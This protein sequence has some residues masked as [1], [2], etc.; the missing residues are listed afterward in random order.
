MRKGLFQDL[1]T[2]TRIPLSLW[3]FF[4]LSVVI[5]GLLLFM[6]AT[7]DSTPPEVE[8]LVKSPERREGSGLSVEFGGSRTAANIQGRGGHSGA[9]R[10]DVGNRSFASYTPSQP[11][12]VDKDET[13][14]NPVPEPALVYRH[15]VRQTNLDIGAEEYMK[16]YDKPFLDAGKQPVSP[17]P[18]R[19]KTAA[20]FRKVKQYIEE[21]QLPPD[22]LVK[23]E[24]MINYFYYDYPLP[25]EGKPF[26]ITAELDTCPWRPDHLL[27]HIGLQGKI[28]EAGRELKAR[29]FVVASNLKI[30]VKFNP[31]HVKA[32]RMIGYAHKK[33]VPGQEPDQA[34]GSPD[35]GRDLR[36]GQSVTTL[37][38]VIPREIGTQ[39]EQEEPAQLEVA[40]VTIRYNDPEDTES[41]SKRLSYTVSREMD[42]DSA[43]SE[44]FKFSAAVA[45]FAMLLKNPQFQKIAAFADLLEMAK[46]ALGKDRFGYRKEFIKLM[47]TYKELL[48]WRKR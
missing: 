16:M 12:I 46:D 41:G 22:Q 6:M 25:G 39:P 26:S 14:A 37:Y 28:V 47:E 45:Q 24:E 9:G 20:S 33:P 27:L 18:V 43:A 35:K 21:K 36:M 44:N 10:A 42:A 7:M 11:V 29:D 38:E 17:M 8:V 4:L 13:Y 23:I 2:E 30:R 32:H 48:E 40:A 3:K 15:P 31:D 1:L 5:H 34:T 19:K